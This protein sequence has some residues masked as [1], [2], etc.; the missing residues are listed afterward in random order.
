MKELKVLI[1]SHGVDKHTLSI[2]YG[3]R[4]ISI[5]SSPYDH[6]PGNFGYIDIRDMSPE[7]MLELA[8]LTQKTADELRSAE[9]V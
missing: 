4:P 9:G 1:T 6:R 8:D 2:G 7:E 3:D 5:S